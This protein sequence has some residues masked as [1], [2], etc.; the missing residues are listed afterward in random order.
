MV[1]SR[2]ERWVAVFSGAYE[3]WDQFESS[4]RNEQGMKEYR[5]RQ[6]GIVMVSL[7]GGTFMM[8]SPEDAQN[9]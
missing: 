5:H 9:R 6:T 7:P 1:L 3:F 2:D 4:G 8:G